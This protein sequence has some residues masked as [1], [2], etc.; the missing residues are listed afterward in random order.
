MRVTFHGVRGSVPTPGPSTVRYGGN[1]VCVEARLADGTL[2]VLDAGTGLR[3]LGKQ[4]IAL[5]AS[6]SDRIH[7]L[8]TH[9]HWDHILGLP[10]FAPLYR[11]DT[12]I[13]LYAFGE[14]A[15]AA[16]KKSVL[17]DGEHFPVRFDD[18]PAKLERSEPKGN[19]IRV[20][21]A[22]IK[23]ISLNHPGGCEGYR[24]DDDDGSSLCYLTDNELNPPGPVTTTPSELARFAEGTGL[25]IHDAQYLPS[26]MPGKRGWGHSLVGEVLDLGRQASARMVAL[27]HH[28]PERDDEALDQIAAEAA[29]WAAENARGMRTIVAAEG[30]TVD[31]PPR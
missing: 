21:S 7:L 23:T 22:V 30:T 8:I 4:L 13:V 20:G 27:H 17:F 2:F 6:S 5:T 15:V 31:L 9:G 11:K 24:I 28:D 1:S 10:F 16:A 26:D 25:L 18:I 29:R 19:E 12:H 14:R 3:T